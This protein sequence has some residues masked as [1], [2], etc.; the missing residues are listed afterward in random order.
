M[1]TNLELSESLENYLEAIL[2]L[3]KTSK[4]ARTKDIAE[5]LGI[6][7]GSVTG[8]LRVL[9]EKGLINYSPYAFITLTP[10]GKKIALEIRHRHKTLKYFLHDILQVDDVTADATACRMEHAIDG[11][12]LKKLISFIDFLQKCPRTGED[13]LTHFTE[14]CRAEGIDIEKCRHCLAELPAKIDK[15]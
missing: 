11:E 4:V 6:K 1:K 13:W 5:K 9:G 12:S 10:E 14:H 7:P 3:E 8:A 2:D 15:P